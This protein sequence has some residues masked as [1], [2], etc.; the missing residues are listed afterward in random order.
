MH[1]CVIPGALHSLLRFFPQSLPGV[2][3]PTNLGCSLHAVPLPPRP[4]AAALKEGLLTHHRCSR[5]AAPA[6]LDPHSGTRSSALSVYNAADRNL[7]AT[8]CPASSPKPRPGKT[9]A[10]SSREN[11]V[12]SRYFVRPAPPRPRIPE[13]RDLAQFSFPQN[14]PMRQ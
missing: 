5:A 10:S 2:T 3:L 14:L 12:I 4:D 9:R 7:T 6:W 1:I 8:V 11:A 13:A